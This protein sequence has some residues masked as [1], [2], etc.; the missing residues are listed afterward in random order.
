V[1]GFIIQRSMGG[2]RNLACGLKNRK[3]KKGDSNLHTK[4]RPPTTEK[5]KKS[6]VDPLTSRIKDTAKPPLVQF[7]LDNNRHEKK[8]WIRTFIPP[9]SSQYRGLSK[10]ERKTLLYV[11]TVFKG[12]SIQTSALEYAF[13]VTGP[14]IV[15]TGRELQ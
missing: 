2:L 11:R 14:T 3:R 5:L 15:Y 1:A 10:E 13:G 4:Y 9:S 8:G 7:I 12:A 6:I